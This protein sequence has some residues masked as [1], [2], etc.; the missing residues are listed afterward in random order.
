MARQKPTAACHVR[1]MGYGLLTCHDAFDVLG[2]VLDELLERARPRNWAT[3]TD[4][5]MGQVECS[6]SACFPP[7]RLT[8]KDPT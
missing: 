7:L 1:L 5:V 4:A 2:G 3:F 8:Q 6:S